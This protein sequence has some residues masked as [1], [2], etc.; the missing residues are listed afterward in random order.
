MNKNYRD[1][2]WLYN[3][4]VIKRKSIYSISDEQHVVPTTIWNWLY[5]LNIPSRGYN[6]RANH[7]KLND[8]L[9]EFLN[10][11]LLG[12]GCLHLRHNKSGVLVYTSKYSKYLKWLDSILKKHGITRIGNDY[13]S[14][15]KRW[16][17]EG[18]YNL[19]H[20]Y[21]KSY[22]ELKTLY[23]KWY[24]NNSKFCPYCEI[25]INKLEFKRCPV[26]NEHS[27]YKKIVPKDLKLTPIT[28]RQWYIGDGSN[29]GKTSGIG[30]CTQAYLYRDIEFLLNKLRDLGFDGS[31]CK[32]KRIYIHMKYKNELLDYIGECPDEINDIYGYKWN[33]Y[34]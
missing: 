25:E 27:L 20:Y 17:K 32:D 12:D 22:R 33:R 7:I 14:S 15:H 31:I 10:G 19:Y 3:E 4:Y 2:D 23:D 9:I 34:E 1:K 26:C 21:S 13:K 16:L 6:Y 30:F 5:K 11:E 18:N 28:L 29:Y 24:L 8:K